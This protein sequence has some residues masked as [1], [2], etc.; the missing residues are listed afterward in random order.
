MVVRLFESGRE[1]ERPARARAEPVFPPVISFKNRG[2]I[3]RSDLD[4]YKAELTAF[5]LG[6]AP[7]EPAR[8][9]PDC[10]IPLK[11]VAA[12]LGVGRRTIGRRITESRSH[13]VDNAAER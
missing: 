11:Q 4:R 9:D 6:V 13:G 7:V 8:A 12:E 10:L 3:H 2:Y 5:A 1:A